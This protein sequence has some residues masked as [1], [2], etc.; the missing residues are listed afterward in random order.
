MRPTEEELLAL[1]KEDLSEEYEIIF[2]EYV[3]IEE[4]ND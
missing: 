3:D 1:I 2:D 4:E